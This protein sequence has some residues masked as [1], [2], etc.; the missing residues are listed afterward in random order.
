M[1]L[2]PAFLWPIAVQVGHLPPGTLILGLVEPQGAFAGQ[3]DFGPC[4][5]RTGHAGYQTHLGAILYFI[6]CYRDRLGQIA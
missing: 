3:P 5:E 2:Y 6:A 4:L 1:C